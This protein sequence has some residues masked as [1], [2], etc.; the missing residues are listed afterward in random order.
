MDIK[1]E[2]INTIDTK[3]Y[4][5]TTFVTD[6]FKE[7]KTASINAFI[8]KYERREIDWMMGKQIILETLIDNALLHYTNT[9]RRSLWT[10]GLSKK[11]QIITLRL[12]SAS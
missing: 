2:S 4:T 8:S 12:K 6:L 9:K 1:K 7:P 3:A 11:T 5:Y 10:P